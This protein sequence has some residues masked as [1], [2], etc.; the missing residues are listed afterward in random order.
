MRTGAIRRHHLHESGIQR[1]MQ[2]AMQAAGI[3]KAASPHTL[4]HS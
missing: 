1:A 3:T 2:R 4:R